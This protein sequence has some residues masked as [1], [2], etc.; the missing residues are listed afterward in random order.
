MSAP[1][2]APGRRAP[3]RA[4]L[5]LLGGPQLLIGL[6]ALLAPR[7]FYG[8][9]P[10]GVSSGWVSR[11][12]PYDEHLVRDVGELFVA[13]AVL[14]LIAAVVLERRLVLA[15]AVAWLLYSV[16]HT[17]FHALNSEQFSTAETVG[18]MV[19]LVW[20]VLGGVAVLW[21]AGVTRPA[22]DPPRA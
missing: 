18:N 6:W 19:G 7:G 5:V 21:L 20:T 3:T 12:G 8:D 9:F 4:L 15:V 22:D 10:G 17:V 1:P 14:L 16:P 2:I 11:L 13:L